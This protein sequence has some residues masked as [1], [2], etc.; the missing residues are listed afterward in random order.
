MNHKLAFSHTNP[1]LVN[2]DLNSTFGPQASMCLQHGRPGLGHRLICSPGSSYTAPLEGLFSP[3]LLLSQMEKAKKI[4][5][6]QLVNNVEQRTLQL[7]MA[8]A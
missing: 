2:G 4:R 7:N 5:E 6:L 1:R 8:L 3:S